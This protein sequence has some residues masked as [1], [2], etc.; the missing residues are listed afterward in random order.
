MK[1]KPLEAFYW[2]LQ[3]ISRHDFLLKIWLIKD[4]VSSFRLPQ[5]LKMSRRK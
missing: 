3:G 2:H 4:G 1:G 5:R